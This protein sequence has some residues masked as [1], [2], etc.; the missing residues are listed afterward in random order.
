MQY[1]GLRNSDHEGL[2]IN[3]KCANKQFLRKIYVQALTCE[4]VAG[5]SIWVTLN[6]ILFEVV[7]NRTISNLFHQQK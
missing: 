3:V 5:E 1:S 7:F 4:T 6:S 2:R